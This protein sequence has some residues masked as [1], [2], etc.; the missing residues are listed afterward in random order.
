MG[1]RLVVA[2]ITFGIVV[3]SA[4]GARA[5]E[6]DLEDDSTSMGDVDLMYS[7]VRQWRGAS[8]DEARIDHVLAKSKRE[9][10]HKRRALNKRLAS[11]VWRD[12]FSDDPGRPIPVR[13]EDREL[14]A[15]RM[16]ASPADAEAM[17]ARAE[18]ALARA[19]VL[20]AQA[21]AA[22]AEARAVRRAC[23]DPDA[24]AGRAQKPAR[25]ARAMRS[26]P[27]AERSSPA[28]TIPTTTTP[29]AARSSDPR[30]IIVVPIESPIPVR[31]ERSSRAI[32]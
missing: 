17:L 27:E 10:D 14:I 1:S 3:S 31:A 4:R 5:T 11:L 29:A 30:G 12:P 25:A 24:F 19:K 2:F 32:R 22:R 7:A 18:A 23:V 21:F 16:D 20:R 8:P 15:A 9:S 28:L 26:M 6:S 13:R